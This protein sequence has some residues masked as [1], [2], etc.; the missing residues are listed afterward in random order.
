MTE[1]SA[2]RFRPTRIGWL[3][4]LGDGLYAGG[5]GA[6]V[7]A[8]WFLAVDAVTREPLFTPSLV[9]GVLLRG[10]EASPELPV[11]LGLVAAYT[12]IHAFLFVAFGMALDFVVSRL[13]E[14][15]DLPVIAVASFVVMELGFVA[16]MRMAVPGVAEVIGHGY[17]AAGNV[18]AAIG[19]A[20]WLHRFALHRE[21][22]AEEPAGT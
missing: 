9:A 2:D 18:F 8:L 21:D 12:M 13:R 17:I 20:T 19:M 11:D 4:V 3:D 16:A 22:L 5:I 15:P 7:V 10:A 1:P 14:T 6:S